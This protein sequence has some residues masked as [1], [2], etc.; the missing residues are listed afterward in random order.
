VSLFQVLIWIQSL[1]V[2]ELFFKF[3]QFLFAFLL[4]YVCEIFFCSGPGINDNGSGAAAN[5]EIALLV[6]TLKLEPVNKI[7]FAWWGAEELGSILFFTV[8]DI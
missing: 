3:T 8:Y 7:R 2:K 6:A 1:Q 4:N 5:L